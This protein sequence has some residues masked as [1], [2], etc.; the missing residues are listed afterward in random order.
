MTAGEIL[1]HPTGPD[2]KPAPRF[3]VFLGRA[4]TGAA[5]YRETDD[6]FSARKELPDEDEQD[7]EE[8]LAQP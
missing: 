4:H 6:G 8:A 3:G 1:F 2:S 5:G 7:C